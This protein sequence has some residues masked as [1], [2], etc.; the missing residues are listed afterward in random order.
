MVGSEETFG[1]TTAGASSHL[2]PKIAVPV[3]A[4]VSHVLFSVVN[5]YCNLFSLP[6]RPQTPIVMIG[7]GTG[8]APFRGFIQERNKMKQEGIDNIQISYLHTLVIVLWFIGKPV[9][10]TILYFGCRH[11]SEDFLYEDEL[12]QYVDDGLLTVRQRHYD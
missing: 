12:K 11:R 1:R 6:A 3:L 8:V 5:V 9:G 7:P 10:D 4:F 2:H